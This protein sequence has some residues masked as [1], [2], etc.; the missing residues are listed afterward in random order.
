MQWKNPR[1]C[2]VFSEIGIKSM[3]SVSNRWN[4]YQRLSIV[5][6]SILITLVFFP[7]AG[8][9]TKSKTKAELYCF[10]LHKRLI[11]ACSFFFISINF[12]VIIILHYS[13]AMKLWVCLLPRGLDMYVVGAYQ[14]V[15][16]ERA[17]KTEGCFNLLA[18]YRSTS[19]QKEMKFYHSYKDIHI[20]IK[21]KIC[22]FIIW[23]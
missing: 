4:R 3:K 8:L 14:H 19:F 5:T 9:E 17:E 2:F 13:K 11:L 10:F 16:G 18:I 6:S 1:F 21:I 22:M 12:N 15:V 20:Y 23:L 7:V